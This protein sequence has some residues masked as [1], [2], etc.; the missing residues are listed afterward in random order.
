MY[1]DG[2]THWLWMG[3]E[4]VRLLIMAGED[5]PRPDA[6]TLQHLANR[7]ARIND[8]LPCD[9]ALA[10]AGPQPVTL[11]GHSGTAAGLP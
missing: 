5:L 8:V 4:R 11:P 7:C 6:A 10:P 9:A 2:E 1:V 3:L